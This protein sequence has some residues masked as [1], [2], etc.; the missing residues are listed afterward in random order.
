LRMASRVSTLT[1]SPLTVLH[2]QVLGRQRPRHVSKQV[3]HTP[4]VHTQQ[5]MHVPADAS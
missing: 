3:G 4:L 1:K 5:Q 2:R